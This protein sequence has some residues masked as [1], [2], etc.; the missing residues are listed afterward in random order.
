MLLN[1]YYNDAVQ[2]LEEQLL[3][4]EDVCLSLDVNVSEVSNSEEI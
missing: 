1:Q 2:I 3:A 4:N